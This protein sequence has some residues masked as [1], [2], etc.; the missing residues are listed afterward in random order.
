MNTDF[1]IGISGNARSGKDT[2]CELAKVALSEKKV[3]AARVAFAD[4]IKEDLDRLCRHNIGCSAFTSD[5]E[6]KSLIRPLLVAYGTDVMR[7][8]EPNWWIEKLEFKLP[9]YKEQGIVPIVTD[10]RY[11]NELEWIRKNDGV[12]VHISRDGIGPAN[13]EE[14]SNNL[15]LE[16]K[17][18]YTLSWP[19]FGSDSMKL[20]GEYIDKIVEDIYNTKI[21]CAL[22]T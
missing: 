1:I 17:A 10:V 8:M 22:Q 13:S 4:Q 11:E 19:T 20:G 14:E 5:D 18:D 6:E 7:K 15:I 21:Q 16:K 3:P 12:C 9:L 2:F